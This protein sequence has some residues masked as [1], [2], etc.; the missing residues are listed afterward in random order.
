MLPLSELHPQF[1]RILHEKVNG[2]V[3]EHVDTIQEADGLM[4]SCPACHNKRN[5]AGIRM[6]HKVA[7][8]IPGTDPGTAGKARWHMTG[9]SYLDVT[10]TPSVRILGHCQWHGYITNGE[11]IT[12]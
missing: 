9:S 7:V 8:W 4:F 12:L 10:L 2:H 5:A 3:W 1:L 6:D 11:A